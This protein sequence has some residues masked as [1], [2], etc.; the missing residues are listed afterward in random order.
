M[1]S[2]EIKQALQDCEQT[3]RTNLMAKVGTF[4]RD[5]RNLQ[6]FITTCFR[7]R[8]RKEGVWLHP[9]LIS[10]VVN[11]SYGFDPTT[12]MS[13]GG[14]DGIFLLTRDHRPKNEMMRRIFDKL[15]DKP[16]SDAVAI[17]EYFKKDL[18]DLQPVRL[19]SH[20]MRLLGIIIREAGWDQL[21]LVDLDRGC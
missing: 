11:A 20:H 13:P 1:E 2:H 4:D 8:C 10:T 6:L 17:A 21:V 9:D 12:A 18:N 3:L 5:G 7:K 16:G 14:K 19:V 15:L